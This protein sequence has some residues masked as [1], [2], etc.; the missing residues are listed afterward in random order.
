VKPSGVSLRD[1]YAEQSARIEQAFAA[2]PQ[3]RRTIEERAALVDRMVG[4]LCREFL[5]GDPAAVSKLC[6]VA[7]GGYG[8]RALFPHSDVDLLFLAENGGV[9][10]RY[11]EAT[12]TISR[13]LWDLRLR[14]SPFNRTLAECERLHGD[15]PEFSIALLDSRFLAGDAQ[16]FARLR[17][18]LL[19][20]LIARERSGLLHN[21]SELTRQRHEKEGD[22]IFHLE[23]NLKN[24]PGAL[25]DFNVAYW[26][27]VLTQE[28]PQAASG[29]P[30]G[31]WPGKLRAEIGQAFDFLAAARCFLHYRQG[32]DDNVLT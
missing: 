22:T 31:L 25:R 19:P 14:L 13:S 15:N 8:R 2:A 5:G 17:D 11:R 10:N 6:L 1:S 3:G 23:P 28:H 24:S 21:L 29:E 9:E 7:L 27:A 16:L 20:R 12:R 4:E 18:D 30:D 32:R 26:V